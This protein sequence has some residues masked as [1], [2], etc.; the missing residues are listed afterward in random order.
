[1][2]LTRQNFAMPEPVWP[3]QGTWTY[4]DYCLLPNDGW[5]YEVIKGVLHM[6]PAP[7]TAHQRAIGALDISY[8]IISRAMHS[9]RS[10]IPLLT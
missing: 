5:R 7:N 2:T 3:E 10:I 9:V 1:M 8:T 6:A 4:A